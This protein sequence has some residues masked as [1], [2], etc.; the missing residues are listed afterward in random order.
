MP[1]VDGFNIVS[2]KPGTVTELLVTSSSGEQLRTFADRDG[3]FTLADVAP[4]AYVVT[5][6]NP[7][8]VYPEVG[9][10]PCV[11]RAN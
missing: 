1:A 3:W 8:F 7:M 6:N 2:L 9:A 10:F 11:A 5:V 4:G